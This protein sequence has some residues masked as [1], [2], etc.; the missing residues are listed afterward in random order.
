MNVENLFVKES[1]Q[2]AVANVVERCLVGGSVQPQ[3]GLPS[4]YAPLLASDPK[5]KIAISPSTNDWIAIIESK[6][7]VD[8][9]MA[10]TLVDELGGSAV[11]IQVSDSTGA[12]GHLF[13]E[14][15]QVISCEFEEQAHDPINDA[16]SI[17]R[18]HRIPF[19]VAMFREV[20]DL[21]RKVG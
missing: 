10:K 16:R 18:Q 11:I 14:G 19:D 9:G 7:V 15:G 20:V 6:E 2:R 12:M 3:W 17:L 1:N 13:Y 5:R 21:H 4:S 8:F